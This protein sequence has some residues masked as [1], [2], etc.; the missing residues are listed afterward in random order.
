[1]Y[2]QKIG[3]CAFVKCAKTIQPEEVGIEMVPVVN[4]IV[5]GSI[6]VRLPVWRV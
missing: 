5:N 1:V 4:F 3:V 6:K 2:M